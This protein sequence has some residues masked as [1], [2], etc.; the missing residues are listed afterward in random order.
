[1]HT[2]YILY[3]DNLPRDTTGIDTADH[4]PF[5]HE[6]ESPHIGIELTPL[7]LDERTRNRQINTSDETD[8][9]S[10][11]YVIFI[12]DVDLL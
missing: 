12:V 1:M 4:L 11:T 9:D 2:A 5:L 10:D 3:S 8:K 6:S 7:V